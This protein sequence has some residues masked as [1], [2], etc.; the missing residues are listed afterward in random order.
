MF[1]AWKYAYLSLGRH[2]ISRNETYDGLPDKL[3]T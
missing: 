1:V 2:N 3:L